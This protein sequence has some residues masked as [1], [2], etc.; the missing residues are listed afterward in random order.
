MI[1]SRWDE[2]HRPRGLVD[3]LVQNTA[4]IIELWLYHQYGDYL[5]ENV[6]NARADEFDNMRWKLDEKE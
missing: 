3:A 6:K 1:K 5:A 4:V 2:V